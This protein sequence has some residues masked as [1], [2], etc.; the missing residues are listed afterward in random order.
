MPGQEKMVTYNFFYW[1]TFIFAI[2]N[3]THEAVA[4]PLVVTLF[5]NNR[6]HT[7]TSFVRAGLPAW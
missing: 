3:G 7:S 4:N 2:V 5:P 6:T 1:G